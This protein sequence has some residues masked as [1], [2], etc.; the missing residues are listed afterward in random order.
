V[1]GDRDIVGYIPVLPIVLRTWCLSVGA[2]ELEDYCARMDRT[3]ESILDEV[4][5]RRGAYVVHGDEGR[6][7]E[8]AAALAKDGVKVNEREEH[9]NGACGNVG[10]A[11]YKAVLIACARWNVGKE[12]RMRRYV[13][14]RGGEALPGPRIRMPPSTT[15]STGTRS[16]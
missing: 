10:V 13:V 15:R 16:R 1:S 2:E 6:I 11:D 5:I 9:V 4:C 3:V 12:G 7:K 14:V 8:N